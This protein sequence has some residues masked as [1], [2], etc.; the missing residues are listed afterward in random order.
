MACVACCPEAAEYVPVT[1]PVCDR[2]SDLIELRQRDVVRS[3]DPCDQPQPDIASC[4]P[5]ATIRASDI[6]TQPSC[7]LDTRIKA[8]DVGRVMQCQNG[9]IVVFEKATFVG[10][11]AN[12]YVNVCKT[13]KYDFPEGDDC[14]WRTEQRIVGSLEHPLTFSY[15]E[16][17]VAGRACTLACRAHASLDVIAN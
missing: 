1:V 14:T 17:P 12:G 6:M 8:G 11:S 13:T 7:Y 9:A 2:T 10:E 16:A 5:V 15:N 3:A 4:T